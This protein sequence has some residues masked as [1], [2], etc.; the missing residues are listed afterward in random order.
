MT[1]FLLPWTL[2]LGRCRQFS[3]NRARAV[4]VKVQAK[5]SGLQGRQQGEA[6]SVV[7][8]EPVSFLR[9]CRCTVSHH[10][11]AQIK[12]SRGHQ[13]SASN[14][15]HYPTGTK[16]A[17]LPMALTLGPPP[18]PSSQETDLPLPPQPFQTQS[19]VAEGTL[20][21]V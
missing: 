10:C 3:A 8:R 4:K 16:E 20:A 7:M 5:G 18:A 2:P 11:A 6:P 14:L 12:H 1:I 15:V 19:G 13:S 9:L 17:H 21:A